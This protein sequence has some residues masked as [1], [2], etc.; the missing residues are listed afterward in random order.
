M[1]LKRYGVLVGKAVAARREDSADTPH[2]QLQLRAA[3]T[4]YR[5]AV[6]VKSE[7][8]PS[9]LLYLIE[10]D[11][12]HPV[13][14]HRAFRQARHRRAGRPGVCLRQALGAGAHNAGQD[15]PL[16]AYRLK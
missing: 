7:E 14:P 16:Q 8:Q 3:G 2:Y 13:L 5:I 15:L 6:N 9:E 4:D 1:L 10:E 12:Q 11:F